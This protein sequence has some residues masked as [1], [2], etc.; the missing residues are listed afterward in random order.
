[1][2]KLHQIQEYRAASNSM[3]T[4][5]LANTP[6]KFHFE[7]MPEKDFLVIPQTSSGKR[8][9]VPLGFLSPDI[10]VNNKL[11]VMNG[12]SLYEFGILSSSVHNAWLRAVAGRFREDFTYSVSVVYNTFPWATPT[13]IQREKIKETAQ[14]ILDARACYP[15]ASLADLYDDTAMKDNLRKAHEANDK[16]VM[17]AYGFNAKL[18][19]PEIVAELFKRYQELTRA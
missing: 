16:A 17:A 4:K 9:Y 18:T 7:N 14:A 12:G 6:S 3:Q 10:I 1:M 5:K 15:N 13:S 8:R 19:E 2:E 11:Q